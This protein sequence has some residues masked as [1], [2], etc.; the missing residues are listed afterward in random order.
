MLQTAQRIRDLEQCLPA[1]HIGQELGGKEIGQVAGIRRAMH[2]VL[3][4]DRQ[5]AARFGEA[6]GEVLDVG[7]EGPCLGRRRFGFFERFARRP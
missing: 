7:D 5:R 3:D 2:H 4:F 6:M 1:R